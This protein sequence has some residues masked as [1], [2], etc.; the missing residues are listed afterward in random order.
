MNSRL[1]PARIRK[2]AMRPSSTSG[3]GHAEPA[4]V[5]LQR[6]STG[7]ATPK[8]PRFS[9]WV[10]IMAV[11]RLAWVPQGLQDS[12]PGD[13]ERTTSTEDPTLRP[14]RCENGAPSP[15]SGA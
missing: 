5:D 4:E 13:A 9:T 8:P 2:Q 10:S 14:Q 12:V 15:T 7:L 1:N 3:W 11:L 6:W